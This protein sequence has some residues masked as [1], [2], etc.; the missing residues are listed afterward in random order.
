[1]R[2]EIKFYFTDVG[3]HYYRCGQPAAA[4]SS[5]TASSATT[6]ART[7]FDLRSKLSDKRPLEGSSQGG[8]PATKRAK[9]VDGL[10][11]FAVGV[12]GGGAPEASL[13][14][15]LPGEYSSHRG[16]FVP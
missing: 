11:P 4:S 8:S 3:S 15:I 10:P 16:S 6:S 7:G 1:M 2:I 9:V 12:E 5:T 13:E 14:V